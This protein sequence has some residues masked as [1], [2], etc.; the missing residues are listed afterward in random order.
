MASNSEEEAESEQVVR[1]IP[2][3]MNSVPEDILNAAFAEDEDEPEDL[4]DGSPGDD[5]D[6]VLPVDHTESESDKGKL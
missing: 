2:T 4:T 3:L 1:D 6:T 5:Q